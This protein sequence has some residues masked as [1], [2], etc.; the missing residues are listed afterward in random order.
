VT[1]F[2]MGLNAGAG[3]GGATLATNERFRTAAEGRRAFPLPWGWPRT[4]AGSACMLLGGPALI[5]AVV[6]ALGG[7]TTATALTDR[8]PTNAAWGTAVTAPGATWFT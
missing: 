8:A 5:P 4:L 3:G 7:T 6:I 2:R 1:G